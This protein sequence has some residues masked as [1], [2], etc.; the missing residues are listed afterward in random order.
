MKTEYGCPS[1][2][3]KPKKLPYGSKKGLFWCSNCDAGHSNGVSK[4]KERQKAK[5]KIRDEQND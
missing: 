1:C 4:K 2:G 3:R 5:K